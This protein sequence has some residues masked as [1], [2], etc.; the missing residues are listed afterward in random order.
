M[1]IW[2]ESCTQGARRRLSQFAAALDSAPESVQCRL[3]DLGASIPASEER[4]PATFARL[5]QTEIARW[6]PILKAAAGN[7]N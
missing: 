7:A 3:G 5:V 4:N 1:N 6:S 2:A